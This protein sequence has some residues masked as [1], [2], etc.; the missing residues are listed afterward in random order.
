M[1]GCRYQIASHCYFDGYCEHSK[2]GTVYYD[3]TVKGKIPVTTDEQEIK[4]AIECLTVE[5]KKK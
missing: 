4:E 1:T 2:P 5:T 3:C